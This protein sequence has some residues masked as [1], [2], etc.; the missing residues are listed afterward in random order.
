MKAVRFNEYGGL[1]VLKIKDVEAPHA[2]PGQ[3]RIAVRA[4]G[5]NPIDWKLRA[6]Y[7]H[8]FMPLTFPAGVGSEAAGIVD[9]VGAGVTGVAVGDAVFG[10]GQ[11][12]VAEH[13]VLRA[14]AHV[15]DTMPMDVAGGMAVIAETATRILDQVH[16]K[17]GETLLIA[18]AAG[19]VGTAVIQL[20]R[21]RGAI[22][23]GTA[24][25]P[26]H[27][28][29]RELGAIPTTYEPGLAARVRELAPLGVNAALDLAG[30]GLIPELI[31][32]VGD[33][34]RV[35]SIA[36]VTAPHHG[37]AFSARSAEHPEHAFAE[38]AR[39][40]REGAFQLRIEQTFPMEH[41]ARAQEVS[42]AGRVSGKLVIIM[43]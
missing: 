4:A 41:I 20:A 42:A 27:A 36:D 12:T 19:G 23:I 10:Y 32:I 40:Y 33:P 2:G 18:G 6:G 39:L 22:V 30:A 29:L 21:Q 1:D 38:V 24:S 3:V 17:P 37:A 31:A 14:W 8:D 28:Y 11:N 43:D 15:P 16:L 9:E 7:V 5:V 35:V 34:A 13:A 26:K 25:A